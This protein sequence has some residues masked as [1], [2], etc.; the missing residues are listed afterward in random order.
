MKNE[1]SVLIVY[2]FKY[3]VLV[4]NVSFKFQSISPG[5]V[6]TEMTEEFRKSGAHKMMKAIDI[7]DAI[8]FA[9]S[10]PQRVNVSLK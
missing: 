3:I 6:E 10:A 5:A 7:V 1:Y 8:M 2:I 9:L 4:K